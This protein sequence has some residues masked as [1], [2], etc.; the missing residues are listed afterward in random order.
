MTT[1]EATAYIRTLGKLEIGRL[2]EMAIRNVDCTHC[3]S[4]VKSPCQHGSRNGIGSFL[5]GYAHIARQIAWVVMADLLGEPT[6]PAILS[7]DEQLD[8]ILGGDDELAGML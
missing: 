1:D 4:K 7:Q 3:P 8:D 6:L 2:E 5:P